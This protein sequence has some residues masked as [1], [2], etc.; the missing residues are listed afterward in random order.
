M[1]WWWIIAFG[2]LTFS[3]SKKQE[4]NE[5]VKTN[6][7]HFSKVDAE[8]IFTKEDNSVANEDSL[9]HLL[10]EYYQNTWVGGDLS[11]GI[12]IAKGNNIIFE[13]YRGY[14]RENQQ[15]PINQSTPLHIASISKTMTAMAIMKLIEAKKIKLDQ[16]ITTL[17]PKFPYANIKVIDLLSHRSGLPKYEHFIETL[18]PK[19][20]ELS[21]SFLTNQDVLNLLIR[22]KPELARPTGTGFMY[23]NTNYA[24]LALI[25]EKVT[26]KDYPTAMKEMLFA[27]LEMKHTFVFQQKDIATAAQSFY[28]KN[29][30]L[31]PL[32]NL[33]LIYGDKNIYT[34]PRDLLKFSQAMF[35]KEFLPSDLK[36]KIFTPYSN[37]KKGINNYGLGFRMKIFDNNKKLTYHNG[38]WHGSN[39]VFVHLLESKVSIIA[40][41][42]KFS[43]RVYSAVALSGLLDDFPLETETLK[44]EMMPN[45]P[46]AL[47]SSSSDSLQ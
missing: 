24:L 21:Q 44:K 9:K 8:D 37:E 43:R 22:Y 31:Y 47:P 2:L 18:E 20:K 11:G 38:W 4:G 5:E 26:Q 33:D 29:N 46:N 1:K 28:Y 3:C 17:F 45:V 23:C 36:E 12:L 6:L 40:I 19:S 41:G 25:I 30:K 15:M 27:P 39:S 34:T 7:P 35:S 16:D 14:G 13:Q 10:Q 42:N 32:N